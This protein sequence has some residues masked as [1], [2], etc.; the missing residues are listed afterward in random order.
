MEAAG[1]VEAIGRGVTEVSPGDRVA[2]AMQ[3]GGYAEYVVIAANKLVPVPSRL[4]TV[5]LLQLCY[6][7]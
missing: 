2:Y 3:Q 6:K 4:M 1:V 7:A 5:R